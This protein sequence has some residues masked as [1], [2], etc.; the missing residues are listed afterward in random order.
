MGVT[1]S[2]AESKALIQAMTNNIQIANEITD[3][4]SSGCDH[5]IASLDSG[6]LQGA[7]Y[8]AGR[9]LFTAIIIPSIK[10]LQ[11]AIDAI[12]VELTT[13]QRADAQIAR[14]GT[15]DRDHLTELKRLRERQLQVIQAQIDENESFMKQVSSLLTGDYG[16]LWSDTS[17]LYHAK[18]QLEIGIREVT[19]KLESLEW[20]LTQT[21]DCF[22]G[23]LVVLQLAIQGATQLSQVFMSSDGSYSTAGLDM[24]WV[25]SLKNQE[26]SPVNAS[27]YTQNHYHNI[28]TQTIKTIKSSSERPLQ[29]SERL[30]AAYED[31]LYFLNKT[32]FDD[33]WKVRSNYD[34]EWDLK[35]NKYAK[36][37]EEDLGKKLQSSGINFRLI[38]NKMGDDILSVNVNAPYLSQVAGIA[39]VF[40]DKDFDKWLNSIKKGNYGDNEGDTQMIQAGIDGYVKRKKSK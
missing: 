16:T 38:V 40:S 19:T 35:N 23:S 6:E 1:Y 31:Y 17:T 25:T 11:V 18:N 27:K 24:S 28:L 8:T 12:Q 39:Q 37:I 29:K 26:I 5:L 7:A 3:R 33:Y 2:A 13:Y 34:G 15:L 14:Y 10:K 22:R 9:G 20:F 4:L 30:V 21:S 36:E 32:A